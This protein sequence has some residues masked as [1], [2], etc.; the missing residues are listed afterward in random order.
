[1]LFFRK[2]LAARGIFLSKDSDLAVGMFF[3][4][5]AGPQAAHVGDAVV[6]GQAVVESA[7]GS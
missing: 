1:M 2:A 7:G 5:G 4:P 6:E 3:L